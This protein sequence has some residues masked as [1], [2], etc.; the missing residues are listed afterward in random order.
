MSPF[1][2]KLE[3]KKTPDESSGAQ[4]SS[5]PGEEV[6]REEEGLSSPSDEQRA[7]TE[8]TAPSRESEKRDPVAEEPWA[9]ARELDVESIVAPVA[10]ELVDP[11]GLLRGQVNLIART[12][13]LRSTQM[14]FEVAET[15]SS[16]WRALGTTRAPFHLSVDTR[17]LVDGTYELRIE[18]VTAGGQSVR[19]KRFGPYIIDNTPPSITIARPAKGETLRGW[20]ELVVNVTDHAS[21]PARVE[22]SYSEKD[23][24][25]TL[26]ELEPEEGEVRGFWQTDE[27]RPGSCQ[28]RATA[29]DR[30][31]N[32]ASEAIDVTIATPATSRPEPASEPESIPL[33]AARDEMPNAQRLSP[34]AAGRFGRVPDWDWQRPRSP[35]A[36]HP[37]IVESSSVEAD[38]A[39]ESS[40]KPDSDVGTEAQ[41]IGTAE[42]KEQGEKSVAWTWKTPVSHPEPEAT[43]EP[44][45]EEKSGPKQESE[46]EEQ[47]D[48]I[49]EEPA[50]GIRLVEPV[51]DEEQEEAEQE[52]EDKPEDSGAEEGGRVVNVNFSRAARGWDI[53]E[54]S[55]LV[56]ETPG[57]DPAR[58]EERR[59]I[60]YHLREHTSVDGRI[61]PEFE[62]L[63][64]DV[65][66]EL[67]P[68]D[69]GN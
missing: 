16:N 39:L 54:L 36:V 52:S 25:K 12:P 64:Y 34:A 45:V 20:V 63:I 21:G 5:R 23:E 51:N 67:I 31:G 56:E 37:N 68:G 1:R 38:D 24:W 58:Q 55:E 49:E 14:I 8:Q 69:S 43:T 19:S 30:A 18:S 33:S 26:A 57:Q 44:E 29:F 22:L 17:Q 28:L 41:P 15:G 32:E 27:C 47:V 50:Q 3:S 48:L 59:Q 62:N 11:G 7:V 4:A 60:L 35:G 65:F 13:D 61:P 2:R 53:W 10:A 9:P 46:P 40:Y 6:G 66:G 42:A